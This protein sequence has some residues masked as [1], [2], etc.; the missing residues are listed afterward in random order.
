[1][2]LYISIF[3]ATF[4]M[5]CLTSPL[6]VMTSWFRLPWLS[7]TLAH[8]AMLGVAISLVFS[9]SPLLGL[10]PISISLALFVFLLS[11]KKQENISQILAI[12]SHGCLA[13]GIIIALSTSSSVNLEAWL[14]GQIIAVSS[15]DIVV[16]AFLALISWAFLLYFWKN[17]LLT[18]IHEDLAHVEGIDVQKIKLAIFIL[19]ALVI[20]FIIQYVG[21]LLVASLL[22]FPASIAR[23]YRLAPQKFVMA[24]TAVTLAGSFIGDVAAISFNWP[25]GPSIVVFMFALW[26]FSWIISLFRR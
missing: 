17:I 26:L 18:A 15:A 16:F 7:E 1:M 6:A 25:F 24:T 8:A 4:F 2:S 23:L 21:I 19:L 11:H 13:L 10:I 22:V 20:S 3:L 14:F 5:A 9:A 12:L